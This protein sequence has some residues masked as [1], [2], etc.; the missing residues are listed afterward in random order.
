M[1]IEDIKIGGIYKV[2]GEPSVYI[3]MVAVGKGKAH[4]FVCDYGTLY[5]NT[6]AL[7]NKLNTT[8]F[9]VLE[10]N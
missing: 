2:D 6:S 10:K 8:D 1:G 3:G 4:A 5:L 9:E 7:K